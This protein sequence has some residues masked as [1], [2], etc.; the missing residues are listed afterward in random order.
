M[1]RKLQ[2]DTMC[3]GSILFCH[4]GSARNLGTAGVCYRNSAAELLHPLSDPRTSRHFLD[5]TVTH[6]ILQFLNG[7]TVRSVAMVLRFPR[8]AQLLRAAV[9]SLGN[10]CWILVQPSCCG[11]SLCCASSYGTCCRM[12]GMQICISCSL[13]DATGPARHVG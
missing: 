9:L 6:Y 1:C 5:L 7:V 8:L 10:V 4:A 12:R 11:T 3:H 2:N 13:S